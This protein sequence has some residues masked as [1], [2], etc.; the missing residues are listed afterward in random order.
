MENKLTENRHMAY[1]K[2]SR[3]GKFTAIM[4]RQQCGEMMSEQ[5][6]MGRY[7][8]ETD[9]RNTTMDRNICLYGFVADSTGL[10]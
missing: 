3:I 1:N 6:T 9:C 2:I 4:L 5:K 8:N 10:R 7:V